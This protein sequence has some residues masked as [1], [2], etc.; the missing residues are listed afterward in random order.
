MLCDHAIIII[1]DIIV[2]NVITIINY[3]IKVFFI[4]QGQYLLIVPVG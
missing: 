3:I 2:V 4:N 1:N